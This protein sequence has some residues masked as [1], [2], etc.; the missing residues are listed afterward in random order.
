MRAYVSR[1]LVVLLFVFAAVLSLPHLKAEAA[2]KVKAARFWIGE[3]YYVSNDS[4]ADM[5]VAPYINDDGRTMVPL[6]YLAYALGVPESGVRWD[7]RTQTVTIAADGRELKFII[8]SPEYTVNGAKK[9][10]DTVPVIVG[11][12][13][14]LPARFVAE[15][16]GYGV[17]WNEDEQ[18]VGFVPQGG[19]V[20]KPE[21]V[22]VIESVLGVEMYASSSGYWRMKNPPKNWF[23]NFS[24]YSVARDGTVYPATI[25]FVANAGK[26]SWYKELYPDVKDVDLTQFRPIYAYYFPNHFE[27]ICQKIAESYEYLKTHF[28]EDNTVTYQL[29]ERLV[30]GSVVVSMWRNYN[31]ETYAFLK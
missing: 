4:R 30:P 26:T 18:A 14:M 25:A 15:A 21:A 27:E 6:R 1:L 22:R 20:E 10:M 31:V 2:G 19:N 12:R 17:I 7:E 3:S 9:R 24:E 11:G 13:T 29:G 23:V 8:G 28:S 5:D 16:L